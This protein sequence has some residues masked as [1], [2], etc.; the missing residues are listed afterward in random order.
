MLGLHIIAL[1]KNVW[2]KTCTAVNPAL[3]RSQRCTSRCCYY[4]TTMQFPNGSERMYFRS[5]GDS[6]DKNLNIGLNSCFQMWQTAL[7]DVK[8]KIPDSRTGSPLE[9][10]RFRLTLQENISNLPFQNKYCVSALSHS[11][12]L[13]DTFRSKTLFAIK[14]LKA[15]VLTYKNGN[16]EKGCDYS[17]F[18]VAGSS[19]NSNLCLENEFNCRNS[20]KGCKSI[21]I[22]YL[23]KLADYHILEQTVLKFQPLCP[24]AKPR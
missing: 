5:K 17:T 21:S 12:N 13:C 8:A 14:R 3:L 6:K 1:S 10:V 18:S 9:R 2:A 19:H 11:Q 7:K 23:G 4:M 22:F 15:V 20:H 16:V 24:V